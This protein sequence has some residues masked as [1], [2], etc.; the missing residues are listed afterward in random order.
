MAQQDK[1]KILF[2]D[3][4]EGVRE[5]IDGLL[6]IAG[7][8]HVPAVNGQEALDLLKKESF[9]LV[10]SDVM[11]PVCD[12]IEMLRQ[13]RQQHGFKIPVLLIS[14]YSDIPMWHMLNIG[15]DAFIGKPFDMSQLTTAIANH[16]KTA[17]E[18]WISPPA[19]LPKLD[20]TLNFSSQEALTAS[21]GLNFGRGGLFAGVIRPDLA[22]GKPVSLNLTLPPSMGGFVLRGTGIVRWTRGAMAGHLAPGIGIEFT[23]LEPAGIKFIAD[24]AAA[25]KVTAQIPEGPFGAPATDLR[26]T[27]KKTG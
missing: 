16:L 5:V 22:R 24:L 23:H 17:E 14:G 21:T 19:T 8:D 25:T 15:A 6:D 1:K 12:G 9:D 20:L 4:D 13:I 7:Y 26:S 2:V 18:R 11:M 27:F 3:D 10:L